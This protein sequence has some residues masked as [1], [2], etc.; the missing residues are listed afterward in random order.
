M[1]IEET[2]VSDVAMPPSGRIS[3]HYNLEGPYT[4]EERRRAKDPQVV[5]QNITTQT[6]IVFEKERRKV[7][8]VVIERN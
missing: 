5:L 7:P 1:W 4:D 8:S 6:G 3:W 2:V